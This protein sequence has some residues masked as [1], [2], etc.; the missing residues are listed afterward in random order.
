MKKRIAAMLL[1]LVFS[2]ASTQAEWVRDGSSLNMNTSNDAGQASIAVYNETPYVIWSES[3]GVSKQIYVK[4][5]NGSS[6]EIIVGS[7]NIHS[8][9]NA[10]LPDLAIHNSNLYATW[11]ESNGADSYIFVKKY[12]INAWEQIGN[13]LNANTNCSSPELAVAD[14]GIVYVTWNESTGAEAY[15]YVKHFN[16]SS[17][18]QDGGTLNVDANTYAT[19]ADI[20][21]SLNTPYVVWREVE[22]TFTYENAFVK[23]FNGTDWVQLGGNLNHD[24]AFYALYSP[25]ISQDQT[26]YVALYTSQSSTSNLC[27]KHYN[28]TAWEQDGEYLSINQDNLAAGLDMAMYDDIPYVVYLE[29][30]STAD[31][32]LVKYYNGSA[33]NL[34]GGSLNID[35]SKN[36]EESQIAISSQGKPYVVWTENNGTADQIF[37]K[38]WEAPQTITSTPTVTVTPVTGINLFSKKI[39]AYPNPAKDIVHFAWEEP[40]VEKARIEIF[41]ISGE[42]I[43]LIQATSPG[44][45]T[46]WNASGIAPGIYFYRAILMVDGSEIKLPA[47]KIAIMR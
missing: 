26:L 8:D 11:R 20:T 24:G 22:S 5:F 17:W 13:T 15:V 9:Y 28:G 46:D 41:N 47:Q 44:Q 4:K 38:H 39:L 19:G 34:A 32:L 10:N 3:N 40:G 23:F 31:Q 35:P 7:L 27:V 36:A 1:C 2:A 18:E 30:G 25:A 12:A 14:N 21:M 43:A 6:W 42:R 16:G 29:D 37:V 33:W 45:G